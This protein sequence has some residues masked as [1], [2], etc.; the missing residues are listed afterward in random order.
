MRAMKPVLVVDD[1]PSYLELVLLTLE[2]HC[3]TT[4]VRG[5]SAPR[6]LLEHLES[7]AGPEPA[8]L[9]L[10]MHMPEMSGLDLLRELRRRAVTAP[11]AF[12]SGAAAAEER[13]ACM[14]AGAIAFLQK[15]VAYGDL[16]RGLKEVVQLLTA[17]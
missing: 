2:D 8:L 17:R 4:S 10:D 16:V 6:P 7:G 3:G 15:P 13:D 12:L 9:L 11:V 5:F 14:A 1:D